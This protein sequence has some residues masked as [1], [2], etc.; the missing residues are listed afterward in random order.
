MILKKHIEELW[1]GFEGWGKSEE[2]GEVKLKV[3]SE[4]FGEGEGESEDEGVDR[5]IG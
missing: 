4:A 2:E 1:C 3:A 5:A